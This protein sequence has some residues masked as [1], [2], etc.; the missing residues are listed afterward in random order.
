MVYE[1]DFYTTRRPYS[2]RPTVSSYTMSGTPSRQVR[3][4]PGLGKVHVTYSYDRL[5]PYVGHKRLTVVTSPPKVWSTRPSVLRR[6]F[7]RIES[8]LRPWT[9]YSATN[10][11]LNSDS[12][13]RTYY[14][15]Y[16]ITGSDYY[17]YYYNTLN[18]PSSTYLPKVYRWYYSWPRVYNTSYWPLARTYLSNYL[19]NYYQNTDWPSYYWSSH[20]PWLKNLDYDFKDLEFKIDNLRRTV[21]LDYPY[22]PTTLRALD[23]PLSTPIKAL[24]Y[25][26]YPYSYRYYRPLSLYYNYYWPLSSLNRYSSYWP[27]TYYPYYRN[28][29]YRYTLPS[30]RYY[31]LKDIF[32][33]ET[34]LIRAQTASLLKRIH[35]PVPRVQRYSWPLSVTT[36]HYDD[37]FPAR[38]SNDNYIHRLLVTSP[39]SK[40]EYTT[41]YTEPVRKYIGSGHLACVSYAGDRGYSR[42]PHLYLYEDPMKND[43]QLLSY[44]IN[45]FKHEKAVTSGSETAKVPLNPARPTRKFAA[46]KIEDDEETAKEMQKLREARAARMAFINEEEKVVRSSVT[47]DDAVKAKKKQEEERLAEEKA[48]AEE[49]AREKA[50]AKKEE[51]AAR[52]A[53]LAR[54]EELAAQA[55]AEKFAEIE[56]QAELARQEELAAKAAAEKAAELER[57]AELARQEELAK[58]AELDKARK[59]EEERIRLEE[60]RRLEEDAKADEVRQQQERLEELAREAKEEEEADLAR[61]AEELAELAR[62][63]AE[64]AEQANKEAEVAELARQEEELAELDRQQAELEE[65]E[66]KERELAELAETARLEAEEA[67]LEAEEAAKREA[68]EIARRELEA[69]AEEDAPTEEDLIQK[70]SEEEASKAEEELARQQAELEELERQEAELAELERQQAELDALE[71]E[72]KALEAQN[73]PEP[74]QEAVPVEEEEEDEETRKQRE[75]DELIQQK[76][77]MAELEK[78]QAELDQLEAEARAL[79]EDAPNGDDDEEEPAIAEDTP[80]QSDVEE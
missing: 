9:G 10:R 52:K 59:A 14:V 60:Q 72:A 45:K 33:D 64:L 24:D 32:D 80:V 47:V 67:Q 70:A 69:A 73:E 28:L 46:Q 48:V 5:V 79:E 3:V 66:R 39:K 41:Y 17:D 76:F 7:D 42:R 18:L 4:L 63:E 2:T 25:T 65:L 51:Q 6:E 56:R 8:K 37:G 31:Y 30:D 20:L 78:Q 71:A 57:Q 77:E 1:S 36:R 53:E 58:Q 19:R 23:Y 34:R 54:Q 75:M 11:Y 50:Q 16:P 21:Y 12:A 13:V 38:W 61:Q 26:Y 40:T 74:E 44:Y 29:Y 55:A 22:T 15:N 49:Q 43:I 35:D 27:S 62:Q 68:D